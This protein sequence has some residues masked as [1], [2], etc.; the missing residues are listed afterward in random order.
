[1]FDGFGYKNLDIKKLMID[2]IEKIR[3][4]FGIKLDEI[5]RKM[6]ENLKINKSAISSK[7]KNIS[8]ATL[9]IDNFQKI[10]RY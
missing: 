7:K 10:L 6:S 5:I 3:I 4:K 8:K 2:I 1:M 9:F